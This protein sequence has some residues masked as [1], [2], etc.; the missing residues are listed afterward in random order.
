M[1]SQ[2]MSAR[3]SVPGA[4]CRPQVKA[5]VERGTHFAQPTENAIAVAGDLPRC[6]GLPRWRF[7]KSGTEASMDGANIAAW[8]RLLAHHDDAGLRDANPDTLRYRAWHLP[9][10]LARHGSGS[11]AD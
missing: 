6:W 5:Q 7:A 10:R 11:R 3:R 2:T 8:P 1:F 4:Q 9:A